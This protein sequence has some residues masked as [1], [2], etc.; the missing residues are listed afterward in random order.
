VALALDLGA[1]IEVLAVEGHLPRYAATVG[2][3]DEAVHERDV[4]FSTVLA[5]ARAAERDLDVT[6]TFNPGH[7]AEEIVRHAHASAADLI[8]VGHRGHLLHGSPLGSTAGRV[9]RHA[10]RPVLVVR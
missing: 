8:V 5:D 2:E 10:H 4:F 9:T 3:V 7:P 1:Q 6:T